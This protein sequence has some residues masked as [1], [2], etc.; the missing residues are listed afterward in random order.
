MQNSQNADI[1][2]LIN[3]IGL[4]TDDNNDQKTIN[5]SFLTVYHPQMN[6]FIIIQKRIIIFPVP[7]S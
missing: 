7:L 3:I 5:L 2:R 1:P 4:F 6:P